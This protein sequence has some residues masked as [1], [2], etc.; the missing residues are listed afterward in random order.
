MAEHVRLDPQAK[1]DLI[2]IRD[3]LL[4]HAGEAPAQRVRLHIRA[5]I[6]ML[7]RR[8]MIGVATSEPGI[9]VLPPTRYPY[10]IYYTIIDDTVIVLHVRHA[11]RREPNLAGLKGR[12]SPQKPL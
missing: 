8:P 7:A 4:L 2:G 9:R 5:R 10:R 1:R 11:S 12:T 3:Y 6:R